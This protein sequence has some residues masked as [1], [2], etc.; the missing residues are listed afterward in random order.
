MPSTLTPCTH[1]V[2]LRLII[3]CDRRGRMLITSLS[4]LKLAAE[5]TVATVSEEGYI[6]ALVSACRDVAQQHV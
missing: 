4:L 6:G 2:I 1:C 5:E 3:R